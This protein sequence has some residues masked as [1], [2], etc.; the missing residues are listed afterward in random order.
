MDLLDTLG[1]ACCIVDADWRLTAL[2]RT[3]AQWWNRPR[4]AL[5]GINPWEAFPRAVGTRAYHALRRAMRERRSIVFEDHLP[6]RDR[7][8]EVCASPSG[9]GLALYVHDIT[10]RKHA[11]IERERLL[12][13]L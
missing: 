6:A 4:D 9:T 3:A 1:A 13:E 5:L 7:W 8:F 2:N 12:A 10:A 11:E